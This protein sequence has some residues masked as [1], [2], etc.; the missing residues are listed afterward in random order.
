MK[1]SLQQLTETRLQQV[2][3]PMQV[4]Y[5]RALEMTGPEFD[6]EV[7]RALDENP[8][9][10]EDPDVP[11]LPRNDDGDSSS[12]FNETAEEMQRADYGSEDDIPAYRLQASNR[13]ADDPEYDPSSGHTAVMTLMDALS[14]Q[15]EML[16]LDETARN[17]AIYVAGNIDSNGYLTRTVDQMVDDL[18]F[19]T[20]ITVSRGEIQDAVNLIR[21]LDPP[22][23]G[24]SDLRQTLL[25][26]LRRLKPGQKINDAI[27]IV[28]DYFDLFANKHYDR[29]HSATRLSEERLRD[30]I[31]VIRTLNPK[32]GAAYE[33]VTGEDK[34][35]RIIPDFDLE[36]DGSRISVTLL[37]SQPHLKVADSFEIDDSRSSSRDRAD[38]LTF[39][40]RKRDEASDFIRT[41]EMRRET[42]LRVMRAIVS[43]QREFFL[44]NDPLLL[45]P[46]ILK[47]I[48]AKTGD[49]LSVI[50]RATAGKYVQT[51]AGIYPLKFFFNERPK[52]DLDA[53]AH[54]LL[55]ALK[56]A[57][58]NEDPRHPLSD[59]ALSEQLSA[60]GYDIARRTVTKY[61]ER[62]GL[63]VARLRRK[64]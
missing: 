57:I 6:E 40:R 4:Q 9:L 62:L 41:A 59:Q 35:R 36:I 51:P 46:M 54:E 2:L 55:E 48:S 31:E 11:L 60:Q 30:A 34:L 49:D 26:Q 38:E 25:L 52:D 63:P 56:Q 50:S 27:E 28:R 32:P 39:I 15:I 61:R 19:G 1:E 7:R 8:A 14:D 18:A 10:E 13:S 12:G 17:L 42:L 37:G 3:S 45:K 29:L 21:T 22:G 53:S 16:D 43:L 47:D 5:A 58:E 33:S 24:A 20:G 23:V 44:T 64:L